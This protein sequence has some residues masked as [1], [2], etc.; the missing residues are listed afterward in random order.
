MPVPGREPGG[1]CRYHRVVTLPRILSAVGRTLAVLGA[2]MLLFVVFQLWGTGLQQAQAQ[3]NLEDD[4]AE[5][6]R[7]AAEAGQAARRVVPDVP[8]AAA[9]AAVE[10]E[11]GEPSAGPA[12]AASATPEPT[13]ARA[14][15]APAGTPD[16]AAEALP[17][18]P[19]SARASPPDTPASETAGPELPSGRDGTATTAASAPDTSG[20][21]AGTREASTASAPAAPIA[22]DTSPATLPELPSLASMVGHIYEPATARAVA[23]LLDPEVEE[24]LPLV[25]PD[26]GEAIARIIIPSIDVDTIVVAGVEIDDLR[27]GP[28]HYSTTPLPGQPGNAAIAGHR[29]TYG[30]PFGRLA[31]LNAG[32]AIIVETLQ[33]RFVYR[34]LPGQPGMAGHTLGFRI[35]APTALEVLDDVGDNRLTLTTCHPKYSSKKRLIVHAALVGDPVVRLPRP[36]EPIGA[37]F[38]RL[39]QP[40]GPPPVPLN[41]APP[42]APT[43]ETDAS[44]APTPEMAVSEAGTP[45]TL[46]PDEG[47]QAGTSPG[48]APELAGAGATVDDAAAGLAAGE[49]DTPA[50]SETRDD[51]AVAAGTAAPG[52]EPSSPPPEPETLPSGEATPA[53]AGDVPGESR[54]EQGA[55]RQAAEPASPTAP[56]APVTEVGFGEGLSGDRGAILPAVLWGLAAAAVWGL[57]RSFGRSGRRALRYTVAAVPFLV[58]IYVMFTYVDRALPAY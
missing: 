21:P 19:E 37:E 28:G 13:A 5:R 8:P 57:G 29:T 27:K 40:A 9:A 53:A 1:G 35:V 20:A 43:P 4:L 52:P 30:A 42:Q 50:A 22:A 11:V 12:A 34:V 48:T 56:R 15:E 2:V 33:G 38:V 39:A 36:G 16:V 44:Q 54:S 32:D 10:P 31:E 51:P 45:E 18:E 46:G 6:F 49:I 24:L 25:Y 58:V 14:G 55:A 47:E 7:Q 26:A 17:A 23:R 3:S 41:V